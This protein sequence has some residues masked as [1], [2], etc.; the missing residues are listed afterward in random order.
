MIKFKHVLQGLFFVLLSLYFKA[1]ATETGFMKVQ[2]AEPYIELHTG[3]GRGYPIFYVAENQEWITIIKQHTNWYLVLLENGKKG[4]VTQEALAQTLDQNG[5]TLVLSHT[6]Q[7]GFSQRQF[8]FATTAGV[9]EGASSLGVSAAWQFTANLA[10]E[11]QYTEA[12]GNVSENKITSIA[13][14]HQAFPHWRFSPYVSLGAGIINTKPRSPLIGHSDENRKSDTLA[15]AV[16]V[17][18][19]LMRNF[20]LTLEYKNY[21]ALTTRDNTEELEEWKAGF[22]VFF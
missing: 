16:G 20:V 3:H 8:E 14:T 21:R 4:W 7:K 9:L 15:A 19:Y 2:I 18:T 6:D 13:L 10:L 11:L 12:L 17:K 1:S 22:A 5:E